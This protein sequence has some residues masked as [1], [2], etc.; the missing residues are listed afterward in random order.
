MARQNE[1]FWN[2]EVIPTLT[3]GALSGPTDDTRVLVWRFRLA[4]TH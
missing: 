2:D 1:R 3:A 4:T